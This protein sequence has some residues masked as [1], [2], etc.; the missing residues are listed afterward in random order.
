MDKYNN[1]FSN[2]LN[3]LNKLDREV[4]KS[5]RLYTEE[6][7]AILNSKLADNELLPPTLQKIYEDLMYIFEYIPPISQP[8]IVF[9]G[10]GNVEDDPKNIIKKLSKR[11]VSTST[12][13]DVVDD[14]IVGD[15]CKLVLTIPKGSK[16]SPYSQS[17]EEFEVLLPIGGKYKIYKKDIDQDSRILYYINYSI[18]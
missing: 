6:S 13:E 15:C 18:S 7:F 10:I 5:V 8:L 1:I 2:Q 4:L 12:V 11:F 9:R 3:F 17:P 14:F 16:V